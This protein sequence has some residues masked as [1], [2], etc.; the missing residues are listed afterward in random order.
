MDDTSLTRML[1]TKVRESG[2]NWKPKEL[3]THEKGRTELKWTAD[4]GR[5]QLI[6]SQRFTGDPA[7]EQMYLETMGVMDNGRNFVYTVIYVPGAQYAKRVIG[8]FPS[9]GT[10]FALAPEVSKGRAVAEVLSRYV[11]PK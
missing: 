8:G 6:A 2:V 9:R 10:D 3:L 1:Y 7:K 4:I 5:F 11:N